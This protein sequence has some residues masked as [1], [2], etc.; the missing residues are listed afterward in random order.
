LAVSRESRS[1]RRQPWQA[2]SDVCS[3]EDLRPFSIPNEVSVTLVEGEDIPALYT[4]D[5]F[6]H[7]LSYHSESTRPDVLASVAERH[8]AVVGIAG[9][10]ADCDVMW[11]VGVDVLAD[12][13]GRGIGKALVGTLSQALWKRGI[14]PYYSTTVSNLQSRQVASSLGFWPAWVDLY[15]KGA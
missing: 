14:I 6:H 7:A 15:A 1:S 4:Q 2:Y 10:S 9:A 13:R 11:Q 12:F 5:Q 8:G 3:R